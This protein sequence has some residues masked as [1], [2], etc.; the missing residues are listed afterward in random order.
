MRDLLFPP[1]SKLRAESGIVSASAVVLGVMDP[2]VTISLFLR[3]KLDR[4]VWT[5]KE[6]YTH[7]VARCWHRQVPLADLLAAVLCY[8]DQLYRPPDSVFVE[9]HLG[10]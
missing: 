1:Q 3:T 2:C 10:R 9:A 7:Y 8:H 5:P 6:G 4:A